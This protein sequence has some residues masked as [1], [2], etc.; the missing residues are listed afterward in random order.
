MTQ[1]V[2]VTWAHA[3]SHSKS[4]PLLVVTALCK[5]TFDNSQGAVIGAIITG[6]RLINCAEHLFHATV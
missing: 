5:A 2:N 4:Q 6:G 1:A 3:Q